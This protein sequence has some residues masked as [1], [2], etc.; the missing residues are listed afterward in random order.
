[1]PEQQEAEVSKAAV[2]EE[3]LTFFGLG[4]RAAQ[5]IADENDGLRNEITVIERAAQAD[6]RTADAA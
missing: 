1:V 4:E 5:A 2:V 3:E 6:S